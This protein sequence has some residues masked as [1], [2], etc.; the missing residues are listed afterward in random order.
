M[1]SIK[2]SALLSGLILACL[3]VGQVI[4]IGHD[5]NEEFLEAVRDGDLDTVSSLLNND[6]N[7]NTARNDGT[8]A[9]A[10]AVYNDNETMVDLLIRSGRDG[11][12]VNAA[13]ENGVSPLHL[14][15][16]N[17]NASIISKLL[18]AGADPNVSKWTGESPLMTCA[19]TGVT[20]AVS[21]LLASGADVNA[22]ENNKN[23]TA[24]MWA[25][26]E[27]H[28]DVVKALIDSGADFNARSKT[29]LEPA[30]YLVKTESTMGQNF[31]TSTRF[32][33]YTGNFT[34]LLFAAQSGDIESARNLLTAGANINEASDEDGSALL[35]A[36]ASGHEV[37]AL[38]L[39]ENGADPNLA[40]AWGLTALHYTVHKGILNMSNWLPS[41]SDSLGWVHEPMHKLMKAL[42][43]KGAN[44]DA[45]VLY[46]LP[47][48]D[49]PFLRV[50]DNQSQIDIVGSTPLLLAGAS[51]DTESIK[52]MVLA[53]ADIHAKTMGGGT[54]FMLTAGGGSERMARDEQQAIE[55]AEYVLSLG[56]TDVNAQLT[57]NRTVNGPGKGRMDGRTTLHFATML[58]WKDMVKFL[59]ANGA[60][61]D[62]KDRYQ[63]SALT[64]AMGD[65]ESRYYRNVGVGRYD[66]RYRRNRYP[67]HDEIEDILLELGAAP[68]AGTIVKKG[69]VD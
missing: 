25:A 63:M 53:G 57:D 20:E 3:F 43:A 5:I 32:R 31:P 61:L 52:I 51:G 12:D 14:A 26:A 66:D 29:V 42:L 45:P 18:R 11:A 16:I 8:S 35:I 40:N 50:H 6:A 64:I 13:N 68:F 47:Y 44:A 1:R 59:A 36:A 30:P 65:P 4:A 23:Q 10:W 38:F 15:C 27:G 60:D 49:D 69:S 55:A 56:K 67:S 48:L 62:I 24:L 21:D 37:M 46:T 41:E 17:Q 19:N 33:K 54:L 28:G 39:L 7:V 34:A 2:L 22:R 58:G 9:L